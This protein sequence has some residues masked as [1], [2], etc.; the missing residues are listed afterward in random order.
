MLFCHS[1]LNIHLL[2]MSAKRKNSNGSIL[3]F[4]SK[5]NKQLNDVIVDSPDSSESE[6]ETAETIG[7]QNLNLVSTY[8]NINFINYYSLL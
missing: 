6:K 7:S 4:F 5:K 2:D 1:A 3:S 8:T